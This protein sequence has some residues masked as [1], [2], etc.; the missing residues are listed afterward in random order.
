[1]F[2]GDKRSMEQMLT[3]IEAEEEEEIYRRPL[4]QSTMTLKLGKKKTT[5]KHF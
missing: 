2:K 5:G 3:D 4:D 1:M